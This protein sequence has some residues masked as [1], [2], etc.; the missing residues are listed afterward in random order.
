MKK[1]STQTEEKLLRYLDGELTEVE[2]KSLL[3]EIRQS[4]ELQKRLDELKAVHA[5]LARK[6]NL[7]VPSKNFTQKVME[8]LEHLPVQ[9]KQSY[10]KG[11]MLMAGV[12]IA[13]GIALMLLSSGVF[14][15]T[16]TSLIM[17]TPP[18]DN[19]WIQETT[20]SI[21]FNAKVVVNIIIFINLALALVVLDR[22]VL[23]PL[24]QRRTSISF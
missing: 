24:F 15:N 13:S 18:I 11:L 19:K 17:E 3:E 16:S 4:I 7:E 12:I 6:S 22:T 9:A 1:L 2:V 10:R 21:P 8:D 20:F 14:D 23:K 5:I